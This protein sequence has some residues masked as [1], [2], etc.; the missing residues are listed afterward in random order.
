M[1]SKLEHNTSIK[2][3]MKSTD[4]QPGKS[5]ITD[6]KS[7]KQITKSSTMSKE[8]GANSGSKVKSVK[9]PTEDHTP[10]K[11]QDTN[12]N[13]KRDASTRSPLDGNPGK[14][15]KEYNETE[16]PQMMEQNPPQD[17]QTSINEN[18]SVLNSITPIPR[19][20]AELDMHYSDKEGNP[21]SECSTT[22][23]IKRNKAHT[24]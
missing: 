15:Q 24:A 7:N 9:S 2:D 10:H 8:A 3:Y 11:E 21:S 13:Q 22:S 1:P 17:T 18:K 5:K 23:G 12:L 4:K 20:N 6:A 14:K 19:E 16:V